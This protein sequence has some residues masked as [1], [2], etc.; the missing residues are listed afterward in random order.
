MVMLHWTFFCSSYSGPSDT[1]HASLQS[2]S[3]ETPQLLLSP[4]VCPA[5]S[6]TRLLPKLARAQSFNLLCVRS[7]PLTSRLN[8]YISTTDPIIQASWPKLGVTWRNVL[9]PS[10]TKQNQVTFVPEREFHDSKYASMT[11][12]EVSLSSLLI[13]LAIF[14]AL[15]MECRRDINL[16][17]LSLI[18]SVDC[19]L[20]SVPSDLEITARAASVVCCPLVHHFVLF[21]I[22]SLSSSRHGPRIQTAN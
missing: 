2:S 7:L 16:L 13:S 5:Y 18:A 20:A 12:N 21:L 11:L 22:F 6:R 9:R 17:S 15:A 8:K 19:T 1:N 14:R 3:C 4:V 10:A